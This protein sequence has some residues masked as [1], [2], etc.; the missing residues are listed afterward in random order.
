[1]VDIHA[2]HGE[3]LV[4]TRVASESRLTH[5]LARQDHAPKVDK[6]WHGGPIKLQQ[7]RLSAAGTDRGVA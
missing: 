3:V 7:E 1:M 5:S 4:P 2:H 6:R